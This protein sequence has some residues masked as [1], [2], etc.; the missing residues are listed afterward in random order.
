MKFRLVETNDPSWSA[1][2]ERLPHDFY[3]LPG[4]SRLCGQHEGGEALAAIVEEGDS[5]LLQPLLRR[6]VPGGGGLFDA[7][8]PYG[9]SGPA[10]RAEG[11]FQRRAL[12]M[13]TD[14][15]AALGCVSLFV[16][17]HPILNAKFEAPDGSVS[18]FH[19][20]TVVV[21]LAGTEEDLWR[22]TRSGHRNQINKAM[23]RHQEARIARSDAD[24][25][26]F[27]AI[28]RQTMERLGAS[29]SYWFGDSYFSSL[30]D[31]LGDRLFLCV[32]KME[33]EMAGAGLFVAESGIVQYHL[34]GTDGRFLREQPTKLMLHHV[35]GWARER[36]HRWLH[37]GGGVGGKQ[38]GLYDFKAGFSRDRRD[39]STWRA[40]C[41][42][43]EYRRLARTR[44]GAEAVLDGRGFFPDY[45]RAGQ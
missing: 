20:K 11:D 27:V 1:A 30:R 42:P 36:G 32:V 19:G 9:Y 12:K 35:R 23:R 43:D 13:V 14:S 26:Q 18:V 10:V 2:L 34:S 5:V 24:F 21:D 41:R 45:R 28:Y 29:K 33:G 44:H 17:L 22:G 25:A 4:Y 16:R 37:L 8:S 39:F 31:T 40:I 15:L 38:D 3:H 7:S 6:E